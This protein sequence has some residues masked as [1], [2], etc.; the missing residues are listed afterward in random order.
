KL[1][2]N[3]INKQEN[4]YNIFV[5]NKKVASI[6]LRLWKQK[7]S[8]RVLLVFL[9]SFRLVLLCFFI[10]TVIHQFLTENPKIATILV[11]LSVFVLSRSR[12]LFLQYMKIEN[13]FLDNL[14]GPKKD[15]DDKPAAK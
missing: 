8:N 14:N 1:C 12:W 4:L 3:L 13:Q 2:S 10:M 9:T 6:Y 5:S 15:E 7:T 11:L